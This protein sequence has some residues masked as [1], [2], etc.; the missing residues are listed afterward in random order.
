[1]AG[2]L[3]EAALL[4]QSIGDPRI[5]DLRLLDVAALPGTP[6]H[7][8]ARAIA[9]PER[10]PRHAEFLQRAVDLVRGSALVDQEH[11]LPQIL[12]EHPIADEAVAD[13]RHHRRLAEALRE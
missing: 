10:S 9:H 12:L 6:A 8:I 1:G 2:L 7:A 5:A 3:T 11:R 13:A 4:A